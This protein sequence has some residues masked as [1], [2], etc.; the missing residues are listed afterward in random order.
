MWRRAL[1]MVKPRAAEWTH[2]LDSS[3]STEVFGPPEGAPFL[4]PSHIISRH[5]PEFLHWIQGRCRSYRSQ[6]EAG[7]KRSHVE[8]KQ[9]D[10]GMRGAIREDRP[11]NEYEEGGEKKW[12]KSRGGCSRAD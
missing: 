4:S 11:G 2:R 10:W 12:E 5:L 7:E 8:V 9:V 6:R 1:V 3:N